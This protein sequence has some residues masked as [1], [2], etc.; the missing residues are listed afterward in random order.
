MFERLAEDQRGIWTSPAKVRSRD[1]SW[2]MPLGGITAGLV[3]T[4]R[5]A[6]RH[7]SQD[8][9]SLR[10]YRTISN[11]GV[12]ALVGAAGGLAL[13]GM[14]THEGHKRETGFLA[15]EAL[16]NSLIATETLKFSFGRERPNQG[17]G[18]GQFFQG[19]KSFPSEHAAAAWSIAGILAHE[20]PGPMTKFLAYGLA[21]AVS[22]SRVR[23]REH[24]PSDVLVGSAL[25]WMVSQRIYRQRHNPELGGAI[26]GGSGTRSEEENEASLRKLGSTYVPLDSWIYPALER[27]AALGYIET[28][29]GGVKPWTRTECSRLLAEAREAV[30]VRAEFGNDFMQAE[31]RALEGSLAREFAREESL[32]TGT[33]NRAL[34]LESAYAR[35][36]SISG[37]VLT[38]GYHLGQTVAYEFGRAFRE[39]NNFV[40]GSSVRATLGPV[41]FYVRGEYQHAPSAPALPGA[42][43][44]IL[45][46]R[47]QVPTPAARP[48]GAINRFALL[49]AYAG[50]NISGLQFSFGKQSLAWGPGPG[51]SL[52]LSNNAEPISMVRIAP[53]EPMRLPSILHILGP[54]RLEQFYGRLEGHT[55]NSQPW[56]YGQKFSF[57]PLRSLEFAYSRTTLVGGSGHPLTAGNVF[58][59][60]L[61]RVDPATGSV[62]GDS[63]TAVDWTWRVPGLRDFVVFYGEIEDDDDL[64][65]FQNLTKSVFRPGIYLT[66]LP[67]LTKWDAHVEWTSSDSPGRKPYQGHGDL[68]YWNLDYRDGYTNRGNLMGNTVGREGRTL[69]AWTRYWISPRHTLDLTWKLSQVRKDYLSGG[70]NWQ[71]VQARYAVALRSGLN[72]KT[73]LQYEHIGSFPLL[74]AGARNNLTASVEIGFEPQR[75]LHFSS[76]AAGAKPGAQSASG[77][78]GRQP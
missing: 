64:I 68:N 74:F 61:G 31:A 48:F 23:A 59:S 16:V 38:D 18:Q 39:G 49:D 24:F 14:K 66:R 13:W 11:G 36:T 52:L 3:A 78:S 56:I 34:E 71:D 57:K 45:A 10:G 2:I 7:V 1:L 55:G 58:R 60:M 42:A 35:A 73:A 40:S 12:T 5:A 54:A 9:N 6:T 33:D 27:L 15:A 63:R 21:A 50:V 43:I 41:F 69:Q 67:H 26:W 65:P 53:V 72:L 17:D 25:G 32:A 29:F 4:D 30:E 37:S 44:A 46:E 22:V 19:G 62:P 8:P 28:A 76:G 77:S 20:Y 75:I 70:A 51:G 47:D